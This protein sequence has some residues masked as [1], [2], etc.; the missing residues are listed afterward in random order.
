MKQRSLHVF[1]DSDSDES[2]CDSPDCGWCCRKRKALPSKVA[3]KIVLTRMKKTEQQNFKVLSLEEIRQQKKEREF[4]ATETSS[5]STEIPTTSKCTYQLATQEEPK[6]APLRDREETN[7]PLKKRKANQ[8]DFKSTAKPVKL[9]RTKYH[10]VEIVERKATE[11]QEIETNRPEAE[12]IVQLS[13]MKR[14]LQPD[15]EKRPFDSDK[16]GVEGI[17]VAA[18][19]SNS[20][21]IEISSNNSEN[22]KISNYDNVNIKMPNDSGVNQLTVQIPKDVTSDYACAQVSSTDSEM[23]TFSDDENQ[24]ETDYLTCKVSHDILQ[25]IDCL[26]QE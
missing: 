5:C 22:I 4:V 17:R 11:N 13:P 23:L 6:L 9:K 15:D 8:C 19:N 10:T 1:P 24:K 7:L 12:Q 16:I 3:K 20:T 25:E 26:L 14:V 21:N 18:C 2:S